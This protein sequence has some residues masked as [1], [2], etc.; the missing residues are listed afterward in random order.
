MKDWVKLLLVYVLSREFLLPSWN[1]QGMND[2]G[3]E[4]GDLTRGESSGG[5]LRM[6][7]RRNYYFS[8]FWDI[9]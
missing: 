7:R 2:L 8:L 4:V 9:I 6:R 3:E 5:F 1:S